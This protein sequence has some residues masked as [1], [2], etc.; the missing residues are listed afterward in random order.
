MKKITSLVIAGTLAAVL[1]AQ[2]RGTGRTAIELFADGQEL[3]A[4]KQ[5]FD[6]MDLYQE[7]LSMNP[8]Y[9][10]A[11]YNMALCSYALGSYDLCVQYADNAAKYER[12]LSDIQNLKGMAMIS[13]GKIDEAKNVFTAVLKKYPNNIDARFGL[14]ELDLLDGRISV[15]EGRYLDALKRDSQNRKALLSLALVSS[16]MG[17]NEAAEQYV[18]Q[19][20]SYYSGEAEVHYMASYLAAKNGDYKVAEQ[21]ARSAVQINGD[22]DKAYSLLAQILF[23]QKRYDEVIDICDFRIGRKRDCVGAWYLK[24][25]S[26]QKLERYYDAIDTY[27]TGLTINPQDEV[28]RNALELLVGQ[29]LTVEDPRRNSW[30]EYH[31]K[32]AAEF[33]R[34][35]DGIS[36]RYEY[37]RAL[38]V[39]PLNA[40]IRQSFADMLERDGLYE[41]YLQQLKFIKENAEVL[42]NGPVLQRDENSPSRKRS[43]EQIKNDDA[44]E[45]YESI[46]RNNISARW[47]IDP[48]YLDKTRWNIGIYYT[49]KPVQ[50]FHADLEEISALAARTAFSG[51]PSTAVDVETDPVASYGEAFRLART[52]GR[53]YFVIMTAEETERTYSI[54]ATIYSARTGTKTSEIHVYRTGN[55]CMAKSLQRFR[56]G[57]L[58]ILPIRGK[59]LQN[60]QGTLLLDLGKNDGI[61]VDAEFNIIRKGGIETNDEGPGIKYNKKD[62]LGTVKVTACDEEI[63][64]GKY[65]KNGFYD[66]L[67][68]GDEIILVKNKDGDKKDKDGNAATDSRPAADSEGK[69]ATEAAA[70][71]EKEAIKESLKPVSREN[72]LIHLI[73]EIL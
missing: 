9:G 45:N 29:V 66:T 70:A 53:D 11:W 6:A 30:A 26:Q 42:D 50:L 37:Q 27:Q 18:K 58:D 20:L 16:E 59:V 14:A 52:Q 60:V 36:E 56:A 22:L 44:I 63:S 1:S 5:W 13:L 10:D 49:K 73:R 43:R 57:V 72:D 25:L 62:L 68:V 31:S 2:G 48:F 67:N 69:A 8:Q 46:M 71:A 34:N 35:F 23:A 64:E 38:S 19:A 28:M 7:A 51:V 4:H 3:Q 54:D 33:G 55:D 15:A 12:N 47:K 41:L 39:A 61:S 65:R 21:R 40:S 32:K 17:K 24:G